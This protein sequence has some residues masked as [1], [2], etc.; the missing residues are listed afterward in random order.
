MA[1]ASRQYQK[2]DQRSGAIG[3]FMVASAAYKNSRMVMQTCG[4]NRMNLVKPMK[5]EFNMNYT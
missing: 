3:E 2:T 5:T 1:T 4:Q